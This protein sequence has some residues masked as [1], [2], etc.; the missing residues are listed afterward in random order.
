MCEL[1][2]ISSAVKVQPQE[3]LKTFFSHSVDHPHGWGMAVFFGNAVSLEKEPLPA[4]KSSYLRERLRHQFEVRNMIA[5]IRQAT[6]GNTVYENCHPFVM[7]DNAG[8]TWT[9]AHNGT[10]FDGPMLDRYVREQEGQTDSERVLCHILARV[11]ERQTRE[12]RALD[13]RERFSLVDG[14]VCELA[15]R[16]KLNL[17][18]YDSEQLYVHTNY[19]DSLYVKEAH[20]TAVFATVPLDADA[21]QPVPFTTPL[22]YR[23]GKRVF[24]GTNHG[25]EYR[26]NPEDM[27]LLYLDYAAL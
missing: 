2:G 24:T 7:R 8:R 5:H 13:A 26:V 1:F 25:H 20:G 19:A 23:E 22:A 27:K 17:L 11:N 10:I 21:W 16:N 12:G 4:Y 3:M 18:L 9:L 6:R 14:T 15:P